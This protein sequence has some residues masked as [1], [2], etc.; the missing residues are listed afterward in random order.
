MWRAG[1]RP[2]IW[3]VFLALIS[4][5][6]GLVITTIATNRAVRAQEGY[7]RGM[8]Y[9]RNIEEFKRYA[10]DPIRS[11]IAVREMK[12][13]P[14]GIDNQSPENWAYAMAVERYLASDQSFKMINRLNYAAVGLFILGLLLAAGSVLFPANPVVS[15]MRSPV[16][17]P[18]V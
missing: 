11:E 4:W 5:A 7:A 3:L 14:S 16:R 8:R 10:A 13:R 6:L 17:G 15:V 9:W 1:E 18:T 2:R 12:S